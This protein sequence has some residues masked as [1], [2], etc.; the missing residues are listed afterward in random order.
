MPHPQDTP[1]VDVVDLNNGDSAIVALKAV[2]EAQST[3]INEQQKQNIT[4]AQVNKNYMVFIAALKAQADVKVP[5][6]V[7]AAE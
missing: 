1:V 3:D 6:V 2:N 4:M 7:Q 5:K